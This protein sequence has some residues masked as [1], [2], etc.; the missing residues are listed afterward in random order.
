M[1]AETTEDGRDLIAIPRDLAGKALVAYGQ[2]GG[3]ARAEDMYALNVFWT[4][5]S[6]H[7]ATDDDGSDA[8][9]LPRDVAEAGLYAFERST[10]AASRRAYRQALSDFWD[11]VANEVHG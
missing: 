7:V 3:M 4:G 11:H 5:V 6:L 10:I 2:S 1:M 8:I 9:H